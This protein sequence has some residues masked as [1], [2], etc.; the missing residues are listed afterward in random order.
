MMHIFKFKS[1]NML[2]NTSEHKLIWQSGPKAEPVCADPAHRLWTPA[3]VPAARRELELCT[4][5][6]QQGQEGSQEVI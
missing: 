5:Q 3:G 1:W 4:A 6:G 2:I